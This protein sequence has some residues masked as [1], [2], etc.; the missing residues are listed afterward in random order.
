M[1]CTAD[2]RAQVKDA[3][4][5][6]ATF[7]YRY[8]YEIPIDVLCKRLADKSQVYTQ[9]ADQRPLGCSKFKIDLE[10]P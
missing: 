9:E 4:Q 5:E 6:A 1:S 7:K 2:S 3:R 8:G 10:Y